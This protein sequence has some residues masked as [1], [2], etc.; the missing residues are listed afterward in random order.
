MYTDKIKISTV[1]L[2]YD[3]VFIGKTKSRLTEIENCYQMMLNNH[4]KVLF[5]VVGD[6]LSDI[7]PVVQELLPYD[8]YLK[9]VAKSKAILDLGDLDAQGLSLRAMESLFL[10]KKL[11]T[12]NISIMQYDFYHVNNVFVLG[13]HSV[14]NIAS[15]MQTPYHVTNK[16]IVEHYE[17]SKWVEQFK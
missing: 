13:V 7:V 2:I 4:F 15:F 11:I 5:H 1:P 16:N 6:E 3:I 9:L 14:E 12:N 10:N 17:I 8:E